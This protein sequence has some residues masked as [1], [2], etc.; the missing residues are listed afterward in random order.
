MVKNYSNQDVYGYIITK[1]LQLMVVLSIIEQEAV[2]NKKELLIIDYF[3]DAEQVSMRLS[4]VISK[5]CSV[6]FFKNE[7]QAFS[8]AASKKYKKLFVDSDVGFFKNLTLLNLKIKSSKT[9]LAVYEEGLGTYRVDLYKGIKKIIL[10]FLGCAIYFG[11]N[12][13][14]KELY[15]FKPGH[16]KAP[17]N[18]KIL[19]INKEISTLISEDFNKFKYIFDA[20]DF[21]LKLDAMSACARRCIIYLSNWELNESVMM[22]LK[23]N[24]DFVIVKPHPHINELNISTHFPDLMFAKSA[25]PAEILILWAIER[26]ASV[27]VLHHGSS[28]ERYIKDIKCEYASV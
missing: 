23:K 22:D 5:D 20:T 27:R 21:L 1:P 2:K 13:L 6:L 11:G 26:F 7:K 10:P 28:A 4:K 18:A 24:S 3:S 12:W 8:L 15:V 9:V 19:E 25:I 17:I 14:V 16:I